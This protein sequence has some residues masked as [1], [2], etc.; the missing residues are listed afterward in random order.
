MQ[1][2]FDKIDELNEFYIGVWKDICAIDSPTNYK[3]GVDRVGDYLT[4]LARE[5]GFEIKILENEIAGNAIAITINPN[6]KEKPVVFSGHIDTVF[7]IGTFPSPTVTTDNEKI[8]GPGVTDCK[9][10]VV[11]SFMALDA[12]SERKPLNL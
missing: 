11:A 2:L 10:G 9:G 3:E 5:R 12:L 7:P 1:E 8:Y 4:K 6:C